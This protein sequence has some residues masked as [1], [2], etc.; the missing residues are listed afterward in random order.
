MADSPT[1]AGPTTVPDRHSAVEREP[2]G[3]AE[4]VPPATGEATGALPSLEESVG[5]IPPHLRQR[6]DEL[7]RAEWVEVCRLPAPEE[8]EDPPETA[9]D[10]SDLLEEVEES[11]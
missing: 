7:F 10:E 11:A 1:G 5:K 2:A 9:P 8:S 6:M 4:F 3:A